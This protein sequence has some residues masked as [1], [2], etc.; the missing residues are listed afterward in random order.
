[1]RKLRFVCQHLLLCSY[2]I[3][4]KRTARQTFPRTEGCYQNSNHLERISTQPQP[5]RPS[6][7]LL[8]VKEEKKKK[9]KT[10]QERQ[11]AQDA[12]LQPPLPVHA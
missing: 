11:K 4:V 8:A 3:I 12:P 7:R 9:K 10:H 1:M 6:E 5:I 2:S